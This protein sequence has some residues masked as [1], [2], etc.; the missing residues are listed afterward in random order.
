MKILSVNQWAEGS[1]PKAMLDTI[2]KYSPNLLVYKGSS[3]ARTPE[4]GNEEDWQPLYDE[5]AKQ[6]IKVYYITGGEIFLPYYS[7]KSTFVGSLPNCTIVSNPMYFLRQ[8]YDSLEVS[9]RDGFKI[10]NTPYPEFKFN[11]LFISLNNLAH[12]H[13]QHLMDYLCKNAIFNHGHI[14]WLNRH[15]Y[16]CHFK[17]YSGE[18]ITLD[19]PFKEDMHKMWNP[20]IQYF[21]TPINVVSESDDLIPF[22]TE[23]TWLAVALSK[24]F[25]IQGAVGINTGLTK[26]GFRIFDNIVDYSFDFIQDVEERTDLLTQEVKKLEKYSYNDIWKFTRDVREHNRLRLIEIAKENLF[27]PSHI[28]WLNDLP[29][30]NF[31]NKEK[32]ILI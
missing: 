4:H 24:M 29:L 7:D 27:I 14:S 1:S 23:K 11:R 15:D 13:R 22:Y 21:E 17:Y 25:F 5:I 8:T 32:K 12:T 2:V 28:K 9:N 26:Y 19:Q 16:K 18:K 10:L 30:N 3:E 31:I 20:P 6:G